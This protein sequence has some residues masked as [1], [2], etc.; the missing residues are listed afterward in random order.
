MNLFNHR[1]L[2]TTGSV[3]L[4]LVV[5]TY[6]AMRFFKQG[7]VEN[8]LHNKFKYLTSNQTITLAG[9]KSSEERLVMAATYNLPSFKE[10]RQPYFEGISNFEVDFASN[11]NLETDESNNNS[12]TAPAGEAENTNSGTSYYYVQNK[13]A[14]TYA[15]AFQ[16][17]SSK[18]KTFQNSNT[19]QPFNTGIQTEDYFGNKTPSIKNTS[20][21]S[22]L[23]NN[24]LAIT[25]DL[26]DN[27]SP[28][29]I[30]GGS[31]PG[32]PGVPVGD[33]TRVLLVL[34]VVYGLVLSGKDKTSFYK[35][36]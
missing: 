35:P 16:N 34:M 21:N 24:T 20:S 10:K 3:V 6:F 36:E 15:A 22:F 14:A 2:I 8:L 17:V 31:N 33:G 26:S 32:D 30:G 5:F 18:T 9:M 12:I 19:V 28:M 13:L 27:N 1:Q 29:L 23:A 25:S 11:I 7:E 4:L